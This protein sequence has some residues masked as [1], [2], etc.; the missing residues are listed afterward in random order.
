[1]LSRAPISPELGIPPASR[2]GDG[3]VETAASDS[4][5]P[6]S[7]DL[8]GPVSSRNAELPVIVVHSDD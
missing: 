1:M 8:T 2:R 6:S 3:I 4:L 5:A 7:G